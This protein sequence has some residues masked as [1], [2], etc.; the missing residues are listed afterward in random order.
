[1]THGPPWWE[2]RRDDLLALA[3]KRPSCLVYNEETLNDTLFDLLVLEGVERVFYPVRANPHPTI[4]EKAHRMGAG[5]SCLSHLEV[6]SVLRLL[7]DLSPD[8]ILLVP[9]GTAGETGERAFH[10]G[11]SVVMKSLDVLRAWGEC[12]KGRN[13][14]AGISSRAVHKREDAFRRRSG[15]GVPLEEMDAFLERAGNLGCAV[16]G[17][18]VSV[19]DADWASFR[20]GAF[21]SFWKAIRSRLEKARVFVLAGSC[22]GND[23]EG[24]DR[25]AT[26]MVV[27][28]LQAR[29]PEGVIWLDPGFSMVSEAGGLLVRA[30]KTRPHK[31]GFV[32]ET[33]S[34]KERVVPLGG[35]GPRHHV[36]NLS[37][38]ENKGPGSASMKGPRE[39]LSFQEG[40]ILLL[41]NMGDSERVL[42]G[43]ARLRDV[44][45]EHYLRARRICQVKI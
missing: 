1:M 35:E 27:E 11:V 44:F 32:V 26:A 25:A 9:D 5:F 30:S 7:P 17:L 38:L 39:G 8:R 23:C 19:E 14:L 28:A 34:G 12:L 10:S 36:V 24:I 6:E 2:Q 42:P 29:Y 15:P 21:F 40:D 3:E 45:S 33:A 4:L 43:G 13:I 31:G 22:P 41:T 20:A 37:R 16:A 18:Y